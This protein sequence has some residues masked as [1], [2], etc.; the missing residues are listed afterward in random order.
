MSDEI[1]KSTESNSNVS[2]ETRERG[3]YEDEAMQVIHSQLMREK[4]EPTEGFSQ[5]PI[6]LIFI[7]GALMFW[8]GV[9]IANYSGAFRS[10]VFDPNWTPGN[11]DQD[12]SQAAFDPM[13]KGKKLFS[14]QCQ[15]CHQAEGQGIPGVYPS[16]AGSEWVVADERLAIKILLLGMNGPITVQGESFNGNMPPVG[17]WS[18]RDIAAVLSYV[19][20]SWGNEAS[21]VD[22]ATV[23]AV[24]KELEGRK[25]A[26]TPDELLKQHPL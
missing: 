25:A 5:M 23:A 26:W 15:Q 1:V 10:D 13:K 14:R 2:Q 17:M 7:F 3:A 20:Y 21:M 18:D 4:E 11:M 24:R 9:Y 16:L 12:Q 22:E 19:R 8:G 6:F